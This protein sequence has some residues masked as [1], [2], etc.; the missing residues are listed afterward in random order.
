VP[1]VF[2]ATMYLLASF[3]NEAIEIDKNKKPKNTDWKS[4]LKMMKN[5]DEYVKYLLSFKDIVDQNIV[6]LSNVAVVKNTYLKM[7]SFTP[8]I[9]A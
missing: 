1:E 4:V 5:P 9:M 3:W 2:A 6:P 7:E 8:E